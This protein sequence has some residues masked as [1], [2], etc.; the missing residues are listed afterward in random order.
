[1]VQKP[2]SF[3]ILATDIDAASIETAEKGEYAP[4]SV[5][6]LPRVQ[7]ARWF[8]LAGPRLLISQELKHLVRFTTHDLMGEWRGDW[9]GFDMIFCRNLLIY[10]TGPQ[11]QKLYE[12]FAGILAPGGY[13]ILGLAETLLGPARRF[14]QCVDV[15]NRIYQTLP[16]PLGKDSMEASLG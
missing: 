2:F 15:R 4:E 16:S 5:K 9:K 7:V 1:M 14:Y 10:L 11:Q 13:L 12:R 6:K 8:R 3:D